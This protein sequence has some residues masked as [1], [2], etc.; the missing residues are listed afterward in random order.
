MQN[1]VLRAKGLHTFQNELSSIP[2]G[3]LIEALN[4]IIDRN[5]IIEPRRGF[6]QYGEDFGN[7]TD[8]PKQLIQY[9]NRVLVHYDDKLAYDSND[10]GIFIEFDGSYLETQTGLRLKS[11]EKLGNLYF[12]TDEG[13]KKISALTASDFTNAA[14][15]ITKAGVPKALDVS[16]EV[17]YSVSG[18]LTPL[19]KVAYKVVWRYIS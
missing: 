6:R 5:E 4:V 19:S 10:A 11:V 13:I 1:V 15:Y 2:E 12:T 18:F 17:D 3:A 8:R 9:K 16:A 7:T 14:G